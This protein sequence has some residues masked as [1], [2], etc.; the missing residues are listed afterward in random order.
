MEIKKNRQRKLQTNFIKLTLDHKGGSTEERKVL[1]MDSPGGSAGL[2]TDFSVKAYGLPPSFEMLS[3]DL[4][5]CPVRARWQGCPPTPPQE[6]RVGSNLNQLLM[7]NSGL[8]HLQ[9]DKQLKGS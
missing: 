9:V 1:R 6:G 5:I 4:C 2:G 8:R 7:W 3:N